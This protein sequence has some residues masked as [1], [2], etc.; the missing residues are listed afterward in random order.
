MF[1][2]CLSFFDRSAVVMTD[3]EKQLYTMMQQV[4][5]LRRTK[6]KEDRAKTVEKRSQLAAKKAAVAK[7]F[8]A[9]H[10]DN[11]KRKFKKE[12]LKQQDRAKFSRKKE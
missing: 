3:E 11:K 8:E 1:V 4:H 10:K 2:P 7:L 5:T 9:R 12:D 6:E